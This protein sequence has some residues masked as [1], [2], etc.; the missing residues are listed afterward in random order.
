MA[1]CY[2]F[3]TEPQMTQAPTV[4]YT[5]EDAKST[6][7]LRLAPI[8]CQRELQSEC[9]DPRWQD[10]EDLATQQNVEVVGSMDYEGY[11]VIVEWEQGYFLKCFGPCRVGE[12]SASS[13]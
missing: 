13:T 11:T 1:L 7:R 9:S 5:P 12:V 6:R 10:L 8:A 4:R 2:R 3:P